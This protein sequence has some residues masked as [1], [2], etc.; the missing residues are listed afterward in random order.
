MGL[1]FVYMGISR[2]KP[3]SRRIKGLGGVGVWGM[4]T[5]VKKE[6]KVLGL[7]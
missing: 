7:R 1:R 4:R 3:R 6:R 5:C 2:M